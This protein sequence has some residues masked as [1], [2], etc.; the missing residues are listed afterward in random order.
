M[1]AYSLDIDSVL[2]RERDTVYRWN[3]IHIGRTGS[4]AD[5]KPRLG[6][7][8]CYRREDNSVYMFGGS[9][10]SCFNDLWRLDLGTTLW[11]CVHPNLDSILCEERG[12][13]VGR[14]GHTIVV[15][16]SGLYAGKLVMF[17]GK[18]EDSVLAELWCYDFETAEWCLLFTP[19]DE[20]R[21]NPKSY[22]T[23]VMWGEKMLLYGGEGTEGTSSEIYSLTFAECT[24]A[25]IDEAEKDFNEWAPTEEENEFQ[26]NE[27][28]KTL[29]RKLE[30]V[31]Y[32]SMAHWQKQVPKC[33]DDNGK[34]IDAPALSGHYSIMYDVPKRNPHRCDP[35]NVM[36]VFGG[37]VDNF[38]MSE[39]WELDLPFQKVPVW[40]RL[41]EVHSKESTPPVNCNH[42]G[43]CSIDMNGGSAEYAPGEDPKLQWGHNQNIL[44]A[45]GKFGPSDQ[46][47]TMANFD[48]Q[49]R[50]WS[51]VRLAR[52]P[53]N[54]SMGKMILVD[55]GETKRWV[56]LCA[57]E[58]VCFPLE[59][60]LREE[61]QQDQRNRKYPGFFG[62]SQAGGMFKLQ[63]P[64]E[65]EQ[66]ERTKGRMRIL[67]AS[68]PSDRDAKALAK[69]KAKVV[70]SRGLRQAEFHRTMHPAQLPD[71]VS[72]CPP[73][74]IRRLESM[75]QY[76]STNGAFRP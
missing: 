61:V 11:T 34:N 42:F 68:K 26:A 29:R 7:S 1:E 65:L 49:S 20:A 12:Y 19:D 52:G 71:N 76:F 70:A 4:V 54:G 8:Q 46:K 48:L 6:Y 27:R 24:Q 33:V 67:T 38:L 16:T 74:G 41:S 22:H 9:D 25:E 55:D 50:R 10:H 66:R 23:G 35:G 73:L 40:R 56:Y 59:I 58:D 43:G 31:R 45:Y 15:P 64:T 32:K 72:S 2:A 30:D 21:A 36:L 47:I 62:K 51:R 44:V 37:Y 39:I 18:C 14:H 63:V 3:T 75:P 5:P 28:Q 17:G 53:S 13:P 57:H 60:H 69:A